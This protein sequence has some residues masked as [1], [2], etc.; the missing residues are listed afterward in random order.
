M[1]VTTG[2]SLNKPLAQD[3]QSLAG[4]I[5]RLNIDGSVP[6]DNPYPGSYVFSYGHRNPQGLAWNDDGTLFASEHG[7]DQHDEINIISKGS[8]YGWPEIR[9]KKKRKEW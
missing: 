9:G 5:L 3:K 8:N 1:Y 7:S 6:E 4:K 2:D